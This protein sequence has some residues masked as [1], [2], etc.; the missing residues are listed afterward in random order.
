MSDKECRSCIDY[1]DGL[2]DRTGFMVDEDDTCNKYTIRRVR[3]T[4]YEEKR[5]IRNLSKC[6]RGR[7]D[8]SVCPSNLP[9]CN[10]DQRNFSKQ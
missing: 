9:Q 6:K 7:A 5:K 2:C 4:G 8:R 1:D 10:D 3:R